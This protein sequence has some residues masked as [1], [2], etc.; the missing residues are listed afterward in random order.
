[1]MKTRIAQYPYWLNLIKFLKN[2]F[3]KDYSFIAPHLHT[4]QFGF[5]PKNSTHHAVLDLKEHVL[6]NCSKKLIS[7]ILFLDLKKAFDTVSHEILLKKLEYYGVRGIALKLFSSYLSNRYQQT[8]IDG[9]LSILE[10]IEW[11]VPQG[12]VLGPL[13]FLIFINDLPLVSNLNTPWTW[14]PQ[15]GLQYRLVPYHWYHM[16]PTLPQNTPSGF[17]PQQG[18]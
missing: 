7:C 13:L 18:H 8:S 17:C 5:Q 15:L 12:S 14:C 1:M 10:L 3:T 2:F 11:G 4:K 16:G 6:E 9:C